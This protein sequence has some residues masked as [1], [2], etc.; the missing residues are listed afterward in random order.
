MK[1]IKRKQWQLPFESFVVND[2]YTHDGGQ[3]ALEYVSMSRARLLPKIAKYRSK[4]CRTVY[5][6]NMQS[7]MS[8]A[9]CMLRYFASPNKSEIFQEIEN[10]KLILFTTD[11]HKRLS[12]IPNLI[13]SIDDI[14]N[15]T[16][17][18]C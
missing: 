10:G 11:R 9:R 8:P 16:I 1:V 5:L 2:M 6:A 17:K 3:R 12:L 18:N 14:Q 4:N 13:H 15:I 7:C